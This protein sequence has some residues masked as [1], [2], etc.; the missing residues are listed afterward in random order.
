MQHMHLMVV[1]LTGLMFGLSGCVENTSKVTDQDADASVR[2]SETGAGGSTGAGGA[3]GTGGTGGVDSQDGAAG[4]DGV[5]GNAS[6][7]GTEGDASVDC[8]PDRPCEPGAVCHDGACQA[9]CRD[10]GN[11]CPEGAACNPR[12]G[13]CIEGGPNGGMA[14][15]ERCGENQ[16][17]PEGQ[18]CISMGRQR[19]CRPDCRANEGGCPEPA[20]CNQESGQCEFPACGDEMMCPESSVCYPDGNCRPD[21][22]ITEMCGQ[23]RVCNMDSGVCER[24]G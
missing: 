1:T 16:P 8:G 13:I 2:G 7:G 23:N 4:S 24:S 22:R 3:D 6:D 20:Q 15:R 21:C 18:V 10:P 9:D 11:A 19:V 14:G 5:G 17:C 12:T